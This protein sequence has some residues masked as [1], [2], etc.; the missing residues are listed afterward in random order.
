MDRQSGQ[1]PGALQV[2]NRSGPADRRVLTDLV[3]GPSS[4][5]Q[6]WGLVHKRLFLLRSGD[7]GVRSNIKESRPERQDSD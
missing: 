2:V 6:H 7:A 5:A 4:M 3:Q 1:L